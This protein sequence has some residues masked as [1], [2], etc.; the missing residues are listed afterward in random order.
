MYD[1]HVHYCFVLFL[2]L[3]LHSLV[4]TQSYPDHEMVSYQQEAFKLVL[5]IAG[6]CFFYDPHWPKSS[7]R[8]IVIIIPGTEV[9]SGVH[10]IVTNSRY[11]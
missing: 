4:W 7:F 9:V 6:M 2:F 3:I 10:T 5:H 8:F 1:N 11:I